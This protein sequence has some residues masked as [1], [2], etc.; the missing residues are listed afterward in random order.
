MANDSRMN[1][2][3][4]FEILTDKE[5]EELKERAIRQRNFYAANLLR[6]EAEERSQP[7]AKPVQSPFVRCKDAR[8]M[9]GGR[10]I[11]ERC[12]RAGWLT[13]VRWGKRLTRPAPQPTVIVNET[14]S[15][16]VRLSA[17]AR[18]AAERERQKAERQRARLETM[19]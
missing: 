13:P 10:C 17:A 5:I 15:H 18:K 7:M 2:K 4:L 12:E 11:L 19:Y 8:V 16:S 1:L 9:L 14:G 6:F 3:M